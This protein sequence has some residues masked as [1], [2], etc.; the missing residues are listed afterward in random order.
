MVT[1]IVEEEPAA[2]NRPERPNIRSSRASTASGSAYSDSSA[3]R[4]AQLIRMA[5]V[6][7]PA[8]KAASEDTPMTTRKR[9][10]ST[11]LSAMAE[12]MP[13]ICEVY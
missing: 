9:L 8:M 13:D 1:R 7:A 6:A 10:P 12:T 4:R 11:M 3:R 5:E 2:R